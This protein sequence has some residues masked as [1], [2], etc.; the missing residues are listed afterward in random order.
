MKLFP[1]ERNFNKFY[2]YINFVTELHEE[3]FL[4]I[5]CKRYFR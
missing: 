3:F 2:I 5:I 4:I 1:C